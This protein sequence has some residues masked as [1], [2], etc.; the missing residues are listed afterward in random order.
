M[1]TV[2]VGVREFRAQL[3]D[4]LA[5]REPV[6][7]TR[8]GHT[9]GYFIP[10][11]GSGEAELTAL[12]QAA[13]TLDALLAAHQADVEALAQEFRAVRRRRKTRQ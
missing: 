4:Y 12:K 7:I 10:A 3:T 9:V 1:E 11:H 2:K 6:T 5:A 13:K 8:H